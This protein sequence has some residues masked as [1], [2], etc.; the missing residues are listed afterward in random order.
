MRF[1]SFENVRS[2]FELD[3]RLLACTDTKHQTQNAK[4]FHGTIKDTY[5]E[6]YQ[7]LTYSI[8]VVF[9]VTHTTPNI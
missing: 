2:M 9:Y 4:R 8:L 3:R 1:T 6:S 7:L 5:T